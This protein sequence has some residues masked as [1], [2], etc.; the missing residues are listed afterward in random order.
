M[1]KSYIWNLTCRVN[2]NRIF[3]SWFSPFFIISEMSQ[4]SGCEEGPCD[5]TLQELQLN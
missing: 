4:K 3:L 1:F 5:K 2:D